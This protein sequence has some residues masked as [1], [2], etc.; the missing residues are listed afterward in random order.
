MI[1]LAI[2]YGE[3]HA[4]MAISDSEGKIALRYGVVDRKEGNLLVEIR[5]AVEREGVEKVIVG[6]PV[7]LSGEETAQT[8]RCLAF[9]EELQRELGA[10]VAVEGVDER[11]TSKDARRVIRDEGG[12][13]EEEHAE[14]A[15]LMLEDK[16]R[17]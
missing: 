8:R 9:T 6:V 15:R 2:D 16:L 13:S 14:A 10:K 12:K 5:K 3:R 1:I 4:G 7:G 17:E 11:F